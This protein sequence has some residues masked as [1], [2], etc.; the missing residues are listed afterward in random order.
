MCTPQ[1]HCIVITKRPAGSSVVVGSPFLVPSLT[2]VAT[3]LVVIPEPEFQS[4]R[5]YSVGLATLSVSTDCCGCTVL[6]VS[7]NRQ[8]S[9]LRSDSR[10]PRI[11]AWLPSSPDRTTAINQPLSSLPLLI[12]RLSV[13]RHT[14]SFSFGLWPAVPNFWRRLRSS[15][16]TSRRTFHTITVFGGGEQMAP[17][18]VMKRKHKHSLSGSLATSPLSSTP[19]F[20]PPPDHRQSP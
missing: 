3:Y 10:Q 18:I 16:C 2:R 14:R 20:S 6:L 4:S 11:L 15:N 19:L 7:E 13:S 8:S 12:N 1:T 5:H 9:T 17:T